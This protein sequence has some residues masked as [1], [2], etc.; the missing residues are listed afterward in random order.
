[1]TAVALV[2]KLHEAVLADVLA[3]I[4]RGEYAEGDRLP[5]EQALA[6]SFSV[7]RYVARQAIQALRDRGLVSVTHGVGQVVAPRH[8]WNLFDPVL[9]EAMLEGPDAKA[10]LQ[11]AGEAVAI[12]WPEVAA[13][14]A[15]R[16]TAA[17]LGRIQAAEDG[18]Q[19]RN[20]IAAAAHNRFLGQV[21]STLERATSQAGAQ[22]A[23]G[24]EPYAGVVDAIAVRNPD[25]A[26]SAM[27]A[28]PVVSRVRR[29]GD[30]GRQR[31][32]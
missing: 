18:Q 10:A 16:R 11:E 30:G 14:A 24:L 17:E 23:E 9:L 25:E 27:A 15:Q 4:V 3:A 22:T 31:P 32:G 7:S 26:R 5:K 29:P 12:V 6:E 21:V 1:M 20:A 13:L 19:L 28:S 8:R 2:P